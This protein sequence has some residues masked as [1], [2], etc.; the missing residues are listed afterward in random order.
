MCVGK[1]TAAQYMISKYR[2][3]HIAL[4]DK[5]KEIAIDMFGL[6]SKDGPYRNLLQDLGLYFRSLDEDVWVK[7]LLG[8][9]SPTKKYVLDDMRFVNEA[10]LLDESGFTLIKLN[11]QE[12]IRQK[13]VLRLYPNTD[14]SAL[15]HESETS[16]YKIDD[17]V[18]FDCEVSSSY[19]LEMYQSLDHTFGGI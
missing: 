6:H 2:Y 13:R 19:L 17:E 4:A 5:L 14:S 3:E 11:C 8:E 16:I 10:R 15:L 12:S 7:Y 18:G 9:L 1:T